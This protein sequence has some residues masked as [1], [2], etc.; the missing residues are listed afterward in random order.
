MSA[1]TVEIEVPAGA[2]GGDVFVIEHPAERG[3]EVEVVV[4]E[5]LEAGDLFEVTLRGAT[6]GDETAGSDETAEE[7]RARGGAA[8]R[9]AA[10]AEAELAGV[11]RQ[12][13]SLTRQI[14][15][16]PASPRYKVH[17]FKCKFHHF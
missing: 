16:D 10:A 13:S 12:V 3:A 15:E 1:T 11:M 5:G 8:E 17:C 2:R 9:G 7:Q 4:P 14:S 6:R